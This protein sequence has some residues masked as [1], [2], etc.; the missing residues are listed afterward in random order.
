MKEVHRLLARQEAGDKGLRIIPVM[1]GIRYD[2]LNNLPMLY[3]EYQREHKLTPNL[4]QAECMT[5]LERLMRNTSLRKDQVPSR[6]L[7]LP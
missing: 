6:T 5:D 3:L 1:Y 7:K 2:E 4:D